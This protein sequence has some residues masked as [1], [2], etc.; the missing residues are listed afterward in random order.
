MAAGVLTPVYKS[1]KPL[2][3][4]PQKKSAATPVVDPKIAQE[5]AFVLFRNV[6]FI[7]NHG[8]NLESVKLVDRVT[9]GFFKR[10]AISRVA[11][12]ECIIPLVM[13]AQKAVALDFTFCEVEEGAFEEI[14][15]PADLIKSVCTTRVL[16]EGEEEAF[17]LKKANLYSDNVLKAKFCFV[18]NP[19]CPIPYFKKYIDASYSKPI[20]SEIS[21]P[22]ELFRFVIHDNIQLRG[23]TALERKIHTISYLIKQRK[24][25]T[26]L[27]IGQSV[28]N[29]LFISFAIGPDGL[30]TLNSS[31]SLPA[32]N[33]ARAEQEKKEIAIREKQS[34]IDAKTI[35]KELK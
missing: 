11:M 27:P 8:K 34:E 15:G 33:F 18:V 14:I 32:L 16:S 20:T 13:A 29:Q 21:G 25:I 4:I 9:D 23:M 24:P 7:Y 17:F 6:S 28:N 10:V 5:L 35:K 12:R 2:P 22:L 30:Q 3:A 19:W 1:P 31:L 26:P